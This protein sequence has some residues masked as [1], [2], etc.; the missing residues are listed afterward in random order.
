MLFVAGFSGHKRRFYS[1]DLKITIYLELLAK[2][3]PPSLRRGVSK[4]VAQK[5]DVP[6]RVVQ[7]ICKNGQAGVINGVVNKWSKNC[8]RKRIEI[9]LESIKNVPLRQRTTFQDL[10]NALG[11][12]KSTLHNH[13][14]LARS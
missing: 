2:T 6:L 7:S 8:G 10:A 1:D 11:V 4:G 9:D 13:D 12:K 14:A 5:F 3:D